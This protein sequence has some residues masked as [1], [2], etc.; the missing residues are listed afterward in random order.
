MKRGEQ[1]HKRERQR[2]FEKWEEKKRKKGKRKPLGHKGR[3]GH[4]IAG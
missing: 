2:R 3:R 1:H 4:H